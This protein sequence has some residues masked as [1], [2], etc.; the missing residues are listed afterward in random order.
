[1]DSHDSGNSNGVSNSNDVSD[2][3]GGRL[4]FTG[5]TFFGT[6]LE[7]SFE[8]PQLDP[9]T[10]LGDVTI[11]RFLAEGGMGRVYEGLQDSPHRTVAVKLLRADVRSKTAGKRF[12]HEVETLGRLTDPGVA[13]IFSTG[14]YQVA[15][16][17]LPFFVMEYVEEAQS[18]TAYATANGLTVTQRLQLFLKA[19]QAVAHGHLKGVVHRDLKPGNM[20]VD[21]YGQPKVIDFGIATSIGGDTT[22]TTM[23]T[24]PRNLIGTLRY[25][26]PE[27]IDGS[28]AEIDTRTD[29]YALGLVLYELL[30][31]K[32]AYDTAGK[33]IHQ[34]AGIIRESSPT[35]LAAIDRSLRGDVSTIVAT[36]LEKDR[37]RRY[38]SAVELAA[39]IERH[40]GGEPIAATS[41]GLLTSL[42]RLARRHR[43]A[44]AI[45]ATVAAAI[46]VTSAGIA[47]FAVRANAARREAVQFAHQAGRE[48]DRADA[49]AAAST[50]LLAIANTRAIQTSLD[51]GDRDA[52]LRV[53][54]E[55]VQLVGKP[56][57]LEL[58]CLGSLLDDALVVIDAGGPV[59]SLDYTPD[60]TRLAARVAPATLQG[61]RDSA[62]TLLNHPQFRR[63]VAFTVERR[64]SVGPGYDYQPLA[65]ST[66][67]KPSTPADASADTPADEPLATSLDGRLIA[68]HADDGHL[69]LQSL[70]DATPVP[71]EDSSARVLA[72]AFSP[73]GS[74]FVAGSSNREVT[75]WD[76]TSGLV[77]GRHRDMGDPSRITFAAS[78]PRFIVIS[79]RGTTPT[80]IPCFDAFDGSLVGTIQ[81]PPRQRATRTLAV[82]S[83]DGSMLATSTQSNSID[84]W[85]SDDGTYLGSL[86]GLR[87]TIESMAFDPSGSWLAAGSNRGRILV[88]DPR[89]LKVCDELIGHTSAVRSIAF[90]PTSPTLASG[91]LD[92]TIRIWMPEAPPLAVLSASSLPAAT[93]FTPD[94][95]HVIVADD[96]DTAIGIWDADTAEVVRRFTDSPGPAAVMRMADDGSRFAVGFMPPHEDRGVPGLV[97]SVPTGTGEVRV[98]PWNDESSMLRL[99]GQPLGAIGLAFAANHTRLV[100]TAFDGSTSGWDLTT[101]DRVWTTPTVAR[102]PL[103]RV[104]TAAVL[105]GRAVTTGDGILFDAATGTV[106]K[107]YKNYGRVTCLSVS[108]DGHTLACGVA[109]GTVYLQN[110]EDGSTS[111]RLGGG[112]EPV[113]SLAFSRDG[114]LVAAGTVAGGV[115]VWNADDGSMA[116]TCVG[117]AASIGMVAFTPDGSRL[118][119]ACTGGTV[120]VWDM[121]TGRELCVLPGNASAP[122]AIALSPTGDRLLAGTRKGGTRL[123][124]LSNAEAINARRSS[125]TADDRRGVERGQVGM[126]R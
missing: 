18:I 95:R 107:H 69:E 37:T 1:M 3:T 81:L 78:S 57:P 33:A 113:K 101:G 110:L 90:H 88:W 114:L 126:S 31:G 9:G 22:L 32:P 29:V 8:E 28:N 54:T 84:L 100:T 86:E 115:H 118:V 24:D 27:Q 41:P 119:T 44:A 102:T 35:P 34:V 64:F 53:F 23:H 50:R 109:L 87:S 17:S 71:L 30:A 98:W 111:H 66:D 82:L 124:G 94:G 52:A 48:R 10:R 103:D 74:R 104:G 11:V 59:S 120:R 7:A 112:D 108:P 85:R 56:L 45:A 73:D 67:G 19:C 106:Q 72:S 96:A 77:V 26:S 68:C 13:R 62:T 55:T 38:S 89:T 25:M 60:G 116:A 105:G 47:V 12:L 122:G 21:R 83:E 20:L 14:V 6:D 99:A 16:A 70:T 65:G 61:S 43:L 75:I 40:L 125:T 123:W 117:H 58:R 42:S 51:S 93:T 39:D 2:S 49:E 15:G 80:G 4:G 63:D 76:T 97:A 92:G 5:L 121:P 46:V 91:S 36:C 79:Q